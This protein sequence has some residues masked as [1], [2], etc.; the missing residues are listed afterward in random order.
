MAIARI[1]ARQHGIVTRKQLL[2]ADLSVD[3]VRRRIEQGLLIPQYRGVYRVGHA[4]PSVDARYM[5]AVLACGERAM[6][7]GRAAGYLLSIVTGKPPPPEVA[8]PTERTIDSVHCRRRRIDPRDRR[9][10]RQIPVASPAYV[11]V[12]LAAELAVRELALAAHRAGARHRTTPGQ[13]KAVL[14]R[15]ANATG[16]AKLR[17]VIGLRVPVSLSKLEA[18]FI[19]LLRKHGLPLPRTNRHVG[20]H[21]VDCHWPEYGLTI[22]LVSYRYH[23]TRWSWEQDHDRRRQA[24]DR[25]EEHR[26]YTWY[27]VVEDPEPTVR[28]LRM[29]LRKGVESRTPI[30]REAP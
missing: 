10:L 30:R 6:L 20:A 18:A 15:R 25:D 11:I 7:V 29:L 26:E 17:E 8:A 28:E 27:D 9:R 14:A 5:A 12:D 22:E 3:K 13:V 1:A 24:R 23:N 16:A 19:A 2:D 4:A 21:R